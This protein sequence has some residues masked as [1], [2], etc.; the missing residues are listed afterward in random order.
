MTA[1]STRPTWVTELMVV[2]GFAALCVLVRLPFW[3]PSVIDWDESTFIL[4]GQE[5]LDG[6]L[7]YVELFENKPPLVFAAFALF[8]AVHSSIMAVRIGGAICVLMAAYLTYRIGTLLHTRKTGVI[9]GLLSIVFVSGVTTSGQATMSE[10]IALVPLLGATALLL[11]P[12]SKRTSFLLGCLLAVAALVRT[13][14]AYV[15]LAVSALI[16]YRLYRERSESALGETLTFGLGALLPPGIVAA[17]Y[18]SQGHLDTLFSATVAASLNY[19]TQQNPLT[20]FA[21]QVVENP[22]IVIIFLVGIVPL[23]KRWG[24][25]AGQKRPMVVWFSIVALATGLSIV[26]SG[27]SRRHYLIQLIPFLTIPVAVS[28]LTGVSARHRRLTTLVVLLGLTFPAWKVVRQYGRAITRARQDRLFDDRG[29]RIARFLRQ[30]NPNREPVYLMTDHI[31]YWLTGTRPP[32]KIV[33]HP[34]NLSRRYL[35]EAVVGPSATPQSEMEKILAARPR[36]IV[37][38]NRPGHLG[39]VPEAAAVLEDRLAA[40]YQLTETIGRSRIYVLREE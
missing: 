8:L 4:M 16:V 34:S 18:A 35:I 39:S 37:T 2:A 33:T 38:G 5:I 14:L 31:A 15:V 13:N 3:F 40:A 10:T 12:R 23:Y 36:Y 32:R 30:A 7:P 28:I 27:V 1:K 29:Y 26:M 22:L 25:V 19:S 11:V 6:R 9:A 20:T 21:F 17:L 24:S